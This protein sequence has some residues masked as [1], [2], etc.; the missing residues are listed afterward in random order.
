MAGLFFLDGNSIPANFK[1]YS[2]N[3][4]FLIFKSTH[5]KNTATP[6][7]DFEMNISSSS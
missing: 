4:I 3:H 1:I 2:Y 6:Q 7:S 5:T